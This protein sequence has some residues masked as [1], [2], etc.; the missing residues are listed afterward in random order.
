MANALIEFNKWRDS[1]IQRKDTHT[2]SVKFW[3]TELPH[4]KSEQVVMALVKSAL[5]LCPET[6]R[7]TELVWRHEVI[8]NALI[9]FGSKPLARHG[10]Y[11]HGSMD[12]LFFRVMPHPGDFYSESEYCLFNM[13]HVALSPRS[14]Y[15]Q[16]MI[17]QGF[18]DSLTLSM[19]R[20]RDVAAA[21][22]ARFFAVMGR[23]LDHKQSGPGRISYLRDFKNLTFTPPGQ[24]FSL[25]SELVVRGNMHLSRIKGKIYDDDNLYEGTLVSYGL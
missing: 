4:A 2:F 3:A 19:C 7:I 21:A 8:T 11:C 23:F 15:S 22:K 1:F 25:S 12:G 24:M 6:N 13:D 14:M 17:F 5:E 20:H 18:F 10:C 16:E 9:E